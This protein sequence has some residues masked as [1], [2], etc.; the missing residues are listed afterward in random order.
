MPRRVSTVMAKVER[1]G[2]IFVDWSQNAFHKTTIAPYSLRARPEPTVSTP[3]SWGEVEACAAGDAEL[4][5][6]ADDVLER[7]EELGDLFADVLSVVQPLPALS[8]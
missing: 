4:R 8:T 6:T 7:V 3:V 5:F 2:K 1:P